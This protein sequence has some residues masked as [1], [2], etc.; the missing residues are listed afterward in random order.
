MKKKIFAALMAGVMIFSLTACGKSNKKEETTTNDEKTTIE[1][2]EI[3]GTNHRELADYS[4]YITL[5]DYTGIKVSVE[6]ADDVD[7]QV[8][9]YIDTILNNNATYEQITDR[10][11]AETDTIN[12]D[13]SGKYNDVAFDKGTAT[14][15]TY[16][17]HGGFIE[18]LDTQLVGL[19][20][21]KEYDLECRFPDKYTNNPD[22]AGKDVIFTVKVNYIHGEKIL[23]E[24]ND[25]FVNK[26]T[27][28]NYTTTE[29]FEKELALEIEE[30]NATNQEAS[31]T[32]GLWAA[33]LSNCEIK[34]YP[35][36]KVKEAKEDYLKTMKEQC[37]QAAESYG[38][39]Y[40]DV[41]SLYGFS[42][43]EKLEEYCQDK[44]EKELEYIM[45][46]CMIAT[47]ENIAVT[48]KIYENLANEVIAGYQLEN[49]EEFEEQFGKEY[50]MES[51]IFEAVG[52][53]LSDKNEM[54]ITDKVEETKTDAS[55]EETKTDASAEETKTDASAE[56]ETTKAE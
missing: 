28:G 18:S 9:E 24:W 30:E 16:K 17:I 32:S 44:A 42:S 45:A 19:E 33:I 36:D 29:A 47:K 39:E 52:V 54:V 11:V 1:Y 37:E 35:E 38:L 13:Y 46:A 41:L 3:G 25:E 12:L 31:Y 43:E 8:K 4:E 40:E 51:F 21:G 10:V 55:T 50:I 49:L 14:N 6:A 22:L 23:P 20:C 2:Y 5:G 56:E 15:Y 53:W 26:L 7:K 27:S 48:D 34:G